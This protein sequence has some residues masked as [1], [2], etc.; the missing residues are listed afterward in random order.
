MQHDVTPSSTES[1]P[2]STPSP[3]SAPKWASAFRDLSREH[4]PT[5]LRLEGTLPAELRGTLYRNGPALF[6]SHGSRYGHW[7]DG[8]GGVSMAKFDGRGVQGAVRLV[9]TTGLA[10]ERRAGRALFGNYGTRPPRLFG[11]RYK[12][13]ANTSV[14][15]WQGRL[16]ALCEGGLPYELDPE[17]LVTRGETNLGGAVVSTFSAHP[18][19]VPSRRTTYNFG[20]RYGRETTVDVYALPD[21]GAAHKLTSFHL[22]GATMVHDFIVT[23]RQL[24]FFAPP[25]R[26]RLF[27]LL[28]GLESYSESLTWRPEEGTEVIVVPID[29]P[30]EILRFTTEPFY[31]WHFANA[32][33]AGNELVV[34]YVRYEDFASNR[35][36]RDLVLGRMER[37]LEGKLHRARIDLEKKTLRTEQRMD[38]PCEFPQ[39]A[40]SALTRAARYVY[41]ASAD[42]AGKRE[43][44]GRVTKHD[45]ERG[46]TEHF[47]LPAHQYS[48]EPIFVGRP[49]G[50]AEDDG[51]LIAL[52]YDAHESTSHIAVLDAR[53]PGAP[54]ARAHFDQALPLT[55]HGTWRG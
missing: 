26:L 37:P 14:M 43:L 54:L 3:A 42:A 25:L 16:L 22:A 55:F 53:E 51:W 46:K 48:S 33:Q 19:R 6:G 30:T 24:I 27:R 9:E 31:Q 1:T 35:T 50:T 39:V 5:P 49:G 45:L 12:N 11:R 17:T 38:I 2:S 15:F 13:S 7:F 21:Q 8:D 4:G 47:D 20:V 18:H 32:S 40:E 10:E 36:L 34:D 52:V 44:V 23:D 29:A 41:L 28:A